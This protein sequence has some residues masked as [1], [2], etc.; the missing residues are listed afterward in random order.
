[1][2][3]ESRGAVRLCGACTTGRTMAVLGSESAVAWS[4]RTS[5][6]ADDLRAT[7]QTHRGAAYCVGSMAREQGLHT[8]PTSRHCVHTHPSGAPTVLTPPWYG[9]S[10]TKRNG[11]SPPAAAPPLT[12]PLPVPS[13]D[14]AMAARAAADLG[15]SWSRSAAAT[16]A[17]RRRQSRMS[18][19]GD[20]A[21]SLT[22]SDFDLYLH[23]PIEM[24]PLSCRRCHWW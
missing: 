5:G 23:H 2:P 6:S 1:M 15:G 24:W 11:S 21:S 18:A 13:C 20:G 9:S 12:P 10:C 8:H 19:C 17:Q 16:A 22:F 4:S 3:R 7:E 14:A